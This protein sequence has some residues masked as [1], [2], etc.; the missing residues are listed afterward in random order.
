MMKTIILTL[1]LI[2]TL[3][4]AN[5]E[6]KYKPLSYDKS[7]SL[8]QSIHD[9]G[10]LLGS[11]EK[12]VYAFIDPLCPYSRKFISMISKNPKMLSKYQYQL[13]LYS[14]PRLNS[15]DVVSAIYMSQTPVERLLETML[16]DDITYN[17]GNEITKAKVKR[18]DHIA[19]EMNVNKRPFIFIPK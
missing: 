16:E 19:K 4:S 14:I 6:S 8:L 9:D 11:G 1:F 12:L 10:I 17:E 3:L 13:F 18:I 2:N 7:L 5:T 15:T